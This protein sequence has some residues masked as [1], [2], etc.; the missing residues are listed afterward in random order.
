MLTLPVGDDT[1]TVETQSQPGWSTDGTHM[2]RTPWS[3]RYLDRAFVV[4]A[5]D[6][7]IA[8]EPLLVDLQDRKAVD[9]LIEKLNAQRVR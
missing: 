1:L 9:E 2:D 3:V 4:T 8:I 7:D 5:S 6:L